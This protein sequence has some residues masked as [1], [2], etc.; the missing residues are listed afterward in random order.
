MLSYKNKRL[1]NNKI[2][3]DDP[4]NIVENSPKSLGFI[5]ELHF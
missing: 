4:V 5:S 1:L 3:Q 2:Y